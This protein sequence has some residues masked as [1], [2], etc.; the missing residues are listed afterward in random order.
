MATVT[1][2]FLYRYRK[3]NGDYC[4]EP[5]DEH[6]YG[7]RVP[8]RNHIMA[9]SAYIQPVNPNV[10]EQFEMGIHHLNV[11]TEFTEHLGPQTMTLQANVDTR[12]NAAQGR[13]PEIETMDEMQMRIIQVNLG[14]SMVRPVLH[15]SWGGG[16]R[17]F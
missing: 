11:F 8:I 6:K 1:G 9:G 4:T 13:G 5:I 16:F 14:N 7:F 10:V 3:S 2:P 15:L 12:K 17:I